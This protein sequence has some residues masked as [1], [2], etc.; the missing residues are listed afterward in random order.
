MAR[1]AA[2]LKVRIVGAE[3]LDRKLAALPENIR[4]GGVRAVK[5]EV[6]EVHEDLADAAPVK[7]GNMR[8]TIRERLSKKAL[9]GSVAITAKYAEFVIHGTSDTPANDFVTPVI[10]LSRRRFPDRLREAVRESVTK[11]GGV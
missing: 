4:A 10:E 1:P 5:A 3:E 8:D 2:R 7:T 11:R 9:S 6:S